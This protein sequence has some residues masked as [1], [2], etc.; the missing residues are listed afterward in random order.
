MTPTPSPYSLPGLPDPNELRQQYDQIGT[1][2][3]F[4][5]FQEVIA[6]KVGVKPED[7]KIKRRWSSLVKC[8]QVL[9]VLGSCLLG[10]TQQTLAHELGNLNHSSVNH[11]KKKVRELYEV[12]KNYQ[13]FIQDIF[14][15]IKITDKQIELLQLKIKH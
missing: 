3:T 2:K 15:E 14:N 8:R 7:L 6:G 9:M 13:Q 12:D 1:Q 5:L 10:L 4:Y 11:S